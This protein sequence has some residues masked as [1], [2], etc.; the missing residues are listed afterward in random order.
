MI[1]EVE[2]ERKTDAH[3]AGVVTIERVTAESPEE[4]RRQI[5][6]RPEAK[7][8]LRVWAAGRSDSEKAL[9][10]SWP[11]GAVGGK[12]IWDDPRFDACADAIDGIS[13][14]LDAVDCGRSDASGDRKW[15]VKLRHRQSRA[16]KEET[17]EAPLGSAAERIAKGKQLSPGMWEVVEWREVRSDDTEG[18]RG[19]DNTL[20]TPGQR[21]VRADAVKYPI[22]IVRYQDPAE[23]LAGG[24]KPI[25]N[26]VTVYGVTEEEALQEA[27][28]KYGG[29][30]SKWKARGQSGSL[31]ADASFGSDEDL[32]REFDEVTG[33]ITKLQ[34]EMEAAEAKDKLNERIDGLTKR[35]RD[36]QLEMDNRAGYAAEENERAKKEA[37]S[38]QK[39]DEG[40]A[41]AKEDE[42]KLVYNNTPENAEKIGWHRLIDPEHPEGD[43]SDPYMLHD[44]KEGKFKYVGEIPADAQLVLDSQI[45]TDPP[46]S[47][48]QRRFMR[49]AAA[50]PGES[51]VSKKVS[52][53]FNESDPGGKLPER[54]DATPGADPE[55]WKVR[56]YQDPEGKGMWS[57]ITVQAASREEAIKNAVDRSRGT[58]YPY[59]GSAA[60]SYQDSA[61]T[62]SLFIVRFSSG[63]RV[64]LNASSPEEARA[65]IARA[66]PN[67]A[68]AE[69]LKR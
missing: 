35:A 50:N 27:H 29:D 34:R 10:S 4:A 18:D 31:R 30:L 12:D 24:P 32:K 9:I 56:M 17:V 45:R 61:G 22:V 48:K 68:I 37:D 20:T 33:H 47:E 44:H 2:F 64:Q 62:K 7:N 53:E 43:P 3:P 39:K 28:R 5:A 42:K 6:R 57:S 15:A 60:R 19:P 54:K 66:H 59:A 23:G 52:G 13:R 40:R 69:V 11:K 26:E 67:R 51:G 1:Y 58:D 36:L 8:V 14:R 16:E 25:D 65:E 41:D 49:W 21:R 38:S 55:L 46:A 63:G